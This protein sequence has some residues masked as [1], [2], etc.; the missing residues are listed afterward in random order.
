MPRLAD[1]SI[2]V[3]Q[4]LARRGSAWPEASSAAIRDLLAR[5][6]HHST[7]YVD[8]AHLNPGVTTHG[9]DRAQPQLTPFSSPHQNPGASNS[10]LSERATDH[11]ADYGATMTGPMFGADITYSATNNFESDLSNLHTSNQ[12]WDYFTASNQPFSHAAMLGGHGNLD[13]FSGFDIPF[14]FEQDQHWDM[15]Q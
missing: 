8:T 6:T 10:T 5:M 7:E 15:L 1:R 2:E 14:W 9:T 11:T 12:E 13:P 3:L 4:H